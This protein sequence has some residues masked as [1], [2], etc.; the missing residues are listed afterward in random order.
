MEE[1][2]RGKFVFPLYFDTVHA[3]ISSHLI[4]DLRKKGVHVGFFG[5]M[6]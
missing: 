6:E 3:H 4:K 5:G 2:R 1:G